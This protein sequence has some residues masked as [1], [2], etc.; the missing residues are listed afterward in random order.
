[1][2]VLGDDDLREKII[3]YC[4]RLESNE[5]GQLPANDDGLKAIQL[6][7][8]YPRL[9]GR[10]ANSLLSALCV[11]DHVESLNLYECF[12]DPSAI[13][14]FLEEVLPR[15]PNLKVLNLGGNNLTDIHATLIGRALKTCG[16]RS[17]NLSQNKITAEGAQGL[18]EG[19]C[20]SSCTLEELNISGNRIGFDG[21]EAITAALRLKGSPLRILRLAKCGIRDEA[22]KSIAESLRENTS[23]EQLYIGFNKITDE[24]ARYLA[25]ALQRNTTLAEL[26]L[27]S[28]RITDIGAQE[29][30]SVLVKFNFTLEGLRFHGNVQDRISR[31]C[32]VNRRMKRVVV[33]AT[34]Q[35]VGALPLS[36]WPYVL[37]K[38]SGRPG[39]LYAT[40]AAKPEIFS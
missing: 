31:S 30:E 18:A 34:L 2:T 29:L 39:P 33:E 21:C 23:L 36:L 7:F 6:R 13:I 26:C 38:V 40:I 19:L 35:D 24:G 25:T 3:D 20:R 5:E 1:M 14:P 27:G 12:R 32:E 10:E 9:T 28:N 16:L 11:N 22:A 4:D 8:F 37:E 17:L 15:H